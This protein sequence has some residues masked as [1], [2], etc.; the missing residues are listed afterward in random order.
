M[1]IKNL[2]CVSLFSKTWH[3]S[4]LLFWNKEDILNQNNW[5]YLKLNE[6]IFHK[7]K[8]VSLNTSWIKQSIINTLPVVNTYSF[9]S[10]TLNYLILQ[11]CF[12]KNEMLFHCF[13][14]WKIIHIRY[15]KCAFYLQ[16]ILKIMKNTKTCM[17]FKEAHI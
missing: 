8:I 11:H 7:R 13:C 6:N 3:F 5:D 12:K 9:P 15:L 14:H 2:T 10:H 16:Y 4:I 17:C 1:H